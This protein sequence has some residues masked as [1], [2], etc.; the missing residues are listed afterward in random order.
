M[1]IGKIVKVIDPVQEPE[2]WVPDT[3]PDWDTDPADEPG[4]DSVDEPVVE[5]EPEEVPVHV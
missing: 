2:T 1:E 5:P 3:I 4:W